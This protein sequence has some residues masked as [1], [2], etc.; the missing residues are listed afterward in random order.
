[1]DS[2]FDDG[3]CLAADPSRPSVFYAG[4]IHSSLFSVCRS[5]DV[6][7]TWPT[8]HDL[9][10]ATGYCRDIA[11]AP[12][13]YQAVYAVGSRGSN[14]V[15]YRSGNG[16]DSWSE[17]TNG[18][19]G[20]AAYAVLVDPTNPSK[21]FVGTT[22]GV[23][24]TTN[25][26]GGWGATGFTQSTRALAYDALD[27][28]LYAATASNGVY[29]GTSGGTAW[30]AM[31]TGLGCLDGL[32]LA[33]EPT[34]RYLFLGTDGGGAWRTLVGTAVPQPVIASINPPSGP[35]GTEGTIA[36][37]EFGAAAG[38]VR[39]AYDS[40]VAGFTVLSWSATQIGFRVPAGAPIAAGQVSIV[41]A[42]A[43]ESNAVAFEVTP[44]T[45]ACVDDSNTTGTEYGSE[46][47]PY[48]TLQEAIGAVADGGTVKVARGTYAGNVTISGK[49]VTIQGGYVGRASYPGTGDFSD[50]S[51]DPD[52]STNQTVIDGSGSACAVTCQGAGAKGSVLAGIGI[53][54]GGA[55]LRGGIQLRSVI[56]EGN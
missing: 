13:S 15:A 34:H 20:T 42:D 22:A 53:R 52:P 3:Y 56:A 8:R 33:F 5:T 47:H 11:V 24:V 18:L 12:S 26:G 50:A 49:R 14:A 25:G 48:N 37:T 19:P 4:G 16:G 55:D 21:A 32:C 28:V 30:S 54:D 2:Y 1:V 46:Q 38:S 29:A 6:G 7:A 40:S 31:N 9:G 17:V 44:L 35:A 23:F 43:I 27:N 41:R 51:R 39:F 36:G 45:V 10:T